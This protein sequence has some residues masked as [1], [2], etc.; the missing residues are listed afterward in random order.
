MIKL[1]WNEYKS[2]FNAN[3]THTEISY[4]EHVDRYDI[5][6]EFRGLKIVVSN[7][8]K[9]SDDGAD[10]E[11]NYKPLA[12]APRFDRTRITTC[13]AGRKAHYRY[14]TFT[15]ASQDSFNDDDEAG[16]PLGGTSY[17]MYDASNQVTTVNADAVRTE[18]VFHPDFDYEISGGKL[19]IPSSLSGNNDNAWEAFVIGAPQIPKEFGGSV[20]FLNNNRLKWDKGGTIMMDEQL[21]PAEISGAVSP[22]ARRISVIITHPAGAQSEFQIMFKLYKDPTQ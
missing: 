3:K 1:S 17:V 4:I 10:F 9:T 18:L 12:N 20:R 16:T 21:N 8:Q 7:L 11:A 19:C 5:W 13:M 6:S 22:A 2:F 15:T 14:I